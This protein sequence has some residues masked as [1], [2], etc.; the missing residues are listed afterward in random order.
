MGV[1][2]ARFVLV[3][4]AAHGGWCWQRVVPLL[5]ARGHVVQAPDLPGAGDDPASPAE[6]DGDDYRERVIAAL[7]PGDDAVVL[8]GHSMGGVTLTRVAEAL[9]ERISCAVYVTAFMLRDG[10]RVRDITL[11]DPAP[12][13]LDA[14][15][16][17]AGGRVYCYRPAAAR[18][19]FYADCADADAADAIVR[20]RP[21]PR[22]IA[23]APVH[24]S[25]A[26]A[27]RVPRIY[28]RCQADR[29]I[30]PRLQDAMCSRLPPARLL[31]MACGHSPFLAAPSALA[32]HLHAIAAEFG[33]VAS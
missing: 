30:A 21:M 16:F 10:E 20:L 19:L 33:S 13:V 31:Q 2:L 6:V 26:R 3:H 9:P 24:W 4:G 25:A 29:A 17:D 12:T 18:E 1:R 28:V 7:G 11:L 15:D 5:T 8:V 14:I 22:I 32:E 27:G 23:Q